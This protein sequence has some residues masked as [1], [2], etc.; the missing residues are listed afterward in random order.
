MMARRTRPSAWTCG[1]SFSEWCWREVGHRSTVRGVGSERQGGKAFATT[2]ASWYMAVR[3]PPAVVA[4]VARSS[5]R[6]YRVALRAAFP[7]LATAVV[8]WVLPS[9]F[10]NRRAWLMQPRS[11]GGRR[12]T[13]GGDS[14][15]AC[16]RRNGRR[17][18]TR[19]RDENAACDHSRTGQARDS[20]KYPATYCGHGSSWH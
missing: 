14:S 2:M 5:I 3:R 7:V 4:A 16:G 19:Y 1:A 20:G 9:H 10:R 12:T 18:S 6:I 8:W 11:T 13:G 17:A 15:R